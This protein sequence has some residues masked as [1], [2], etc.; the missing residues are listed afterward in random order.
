MIPEDPVLNDLK[1]GSFFL[2]ILLISA[3]GCIGKKNK[4]A[5]KPKKTEIA[6]QVNIPVTG[7]QV[8]SFFDEDIEAF[9]M[10]DDAAAPSK[11]ICSKQD[12][13]LDDF[14]WV[15]ESKDSEF[16]PIYFEFNSS[17]VS[18]EQRDSVQKD[19]ELAKQTIEQGETP[20]VVIE[21]HACHAAGSRTYNMA[22]S[23]KRA[24]ETADRFVMAGVPRENIKI[25]ARGSDVPAHDKQG[26]IIT[27]DRQQQWPNRRSEIRVINS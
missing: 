27:G 23:E 3:P 17:Q 15:E 26:K 13:A 9:V 22:L 4:I 21:G 8:K 14:A 20:T 19:I 18:K 2:L 11:Q 6:N 1:K 24:K 16:N 7:D 5:D 12:I 25:V 10:L